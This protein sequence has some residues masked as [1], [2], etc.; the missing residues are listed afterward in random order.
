SHQQ[1]VTLSGSPQIQP[2][3]A[4]T[5]KNNAPIAGIEG[6]LYHIAGCCHPLPGEAIMGVVTRGA[7]GISIHRQGCHNLEQMDGDRLI[8]VRWNPNNTGQQ[9]YPVDIVIEAID[10]V[11]VLK[12]ILSRLSDNQI[13][14][15]NA[16][17]KTS[18]GHP[19]L[20][21]LKID[22]RDHAQLLNIIAKIKNMADVIELR[23]V[24]SG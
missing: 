21:S 24:I 14:V 2:T 8:P 3:P 4:P 23:R 13:N 5:G 20:I 6:L 16:D 7:K 18:L 11:G 15:R 22:I 9:T 19:A 1:E 10:R 17:V 12:D